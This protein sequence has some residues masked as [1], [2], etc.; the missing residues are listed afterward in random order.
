LFR[1]VIVLLFATLMYYIPDWAFID[2]FGWLT[3]NP[4][5]LIAIPVYALAAFLL[6][7]IIRRKIWI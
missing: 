2:T 3:S 1:Y 6:Y 4:S 7:R 5:K